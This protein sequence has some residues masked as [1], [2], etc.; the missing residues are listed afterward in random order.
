MSHAISVVSGEDPPSVATSEV[1]VKGKRGGRL[2]RKFN[3][4]GNCS[5]TSRQSGRKVVASAT[6]PPEKNEIFI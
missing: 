5:R 4:R 2:K 1:D 3:P 6:N